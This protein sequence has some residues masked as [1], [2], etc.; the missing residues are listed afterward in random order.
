MNYRNAAYTK[1]DEITC[2]IDH[3]D[4]GWIP[5]TCHRDDTGALFDVVALYDSMAA[6]STT[7]AYVPLTAEEV[8]AEDAR[9]IRF[10]RHRILVDTVDPLV[11]NQL[12]WNDLTSTQQTDLTNYRQALLD[13]TNQLG[14]PSTVTWPTKPDWM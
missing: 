7:V 10:Q 2:E 5:F 8:A 9:E 14:F 13:I 12:R 4:L 11:S 3:P 1:I 6:D